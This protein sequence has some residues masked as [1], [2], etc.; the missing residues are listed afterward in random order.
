MEYAGKKL[1]LMLSTSP[2]HRNLDTVVAALVAGVAAAIQ[3][4]IDRAVSE[5]VSSVKGNGS[6]RR[7]MGSIESPPAEG[8]RA[9]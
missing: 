4:R 7:S 3:S 5:V 2:G 9:D 8:V 1:G 6:S